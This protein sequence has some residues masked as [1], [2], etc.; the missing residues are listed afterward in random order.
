MTFLNL[1]NNIITLL[2]AIILYSFIIRKWGVEKTV[3]KIIAGFL[4]GVTAVIGMMN[5]VYLTQGV[6]LDS[7]SVI[8]SLG[9]LFG[10][11]VTAVVSVLIAGTYRYILGGVG[12]IVGIVVVIIS[13]SLGV[14]FRH[15][16]RN[17]LSLK[18]PGMLYVFGLVVHIITATLIYA[19]PGIALSSFLIKV[20]VPMIGI[21]PL[22]T[23][24]LGYLLYD[25]ER[26]DR[27]RIK[28]IESE[29]K[30]KN[31]FLKSPYPIMMVAEDG[32]VVQVNDAFSKI[33]G[34]LLQDIPTASV[35]AQLA[36]GDDYENLVRLIKRLASSDEPVEEGE[37]QI[38]TKSGDVRV[39]DIHS[40]QAGKLHDGRKLFVITAIDNTERQSKD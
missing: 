15:L 30:F 11:P 4:F 40:V 2:S 39:W 18:K 33:T 1:A 16:I 6:I 3:G 29:L 5:S 31:T 10:G 27:S 13:S 14:V 38:L 35:W 32:E 24:F 7:R 25:Q 23:L 17:D 12:M 22:V 20:L 19:I 26:L 28:L 36:Y 34:Y 37:T 8:L 9:G 21:F